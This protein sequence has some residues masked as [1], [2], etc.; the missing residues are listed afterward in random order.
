[1]EGAA[2]LLDYALARETRS[3]DANRAALGLG[4]LSVEAIAQAAALVTLAGGARDSATA[5]GI[6]ARAPRIQ[7]QVADRCERLVSLLHRLYP[8]GRPA[9]EPDDDEPA[10]GAWLEAVRPDLLGEHLVHQELRRDASLIDAA[11]AE[12][13][14]AS[15]VASALTVL[16]RLAKRRSG[17]MAQEGI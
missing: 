9:G 15:H 11:L 7:G 4:D 2:D 14:A 12:G 6:V 17:A 5:R 16:T 3:W 10:G 1:M 13:A 8:G